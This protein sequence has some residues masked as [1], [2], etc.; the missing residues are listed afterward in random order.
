[1]LFLLGSMS[2]RAQ[3]QV[4]DQV[5]HFNNALIQQTDSRDIPVEVIERYRADGAFD[6]RYGYQQTIS[7]WDQFWGWVLQQLSKLFGE[8]NFSF[9]IGWLLYIFCAAMIIFAVLKLMGV[10]ISGL[11]N[12]QSQVANVSMQDILGEDIHELNFEE[13]ISKA[14][15]AQDYRKAIRLL[16]I[17]TLKKLTDSA[18]IEWHPGKTNADYQRELKANHLQ[19]NFRSLSIYYEYAWYGEFPVDIALYEK[20]NLLHKAIDQQLAVSA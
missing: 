4:P 20:V 6:Y 7:L 11:F 17:Y 18:L 9:P 15:Q 12:R 5:Y 2:G 10:N 19:N 14:Q 8:V 13:E 1:M 16:Y 3:E